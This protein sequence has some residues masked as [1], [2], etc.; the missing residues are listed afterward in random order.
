MFEWSTELRSNIDV[1]MNL[2]ASLNLMIPFTDLI[3]LN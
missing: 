3:N 1:W 2:S